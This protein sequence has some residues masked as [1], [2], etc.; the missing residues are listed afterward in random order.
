MKIKLI[1]TVNTGVTGDALIYRL[2]G[3]SVTKI[4]KFADGFCNIYEGDTKHGFEWRGSVEKTIEE[5]LK[6]NN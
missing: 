5:F 3:N 6:S 2:E 4:M 1:G